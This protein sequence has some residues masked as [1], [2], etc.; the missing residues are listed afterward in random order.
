M[1]RSLILLSLGLLL[2]PG[3]SQAKDTRWYKGNTHCHTL[4]SDGDDY[5]RRVIRW[6]RDH[7]YNFISITD[8]NLITETRYLDTDPNDDFILI[9][10]EE[11]TDSFKGTPIH[12]NALGARIQIEPQR[13]DS[14]VLTLQNNVDAIRNAKAVPQINHPTWKWSFTDVEMAQLSGVRLFELYNVN[15]TSN[16]FSAGGRPGMEEI[17]DGILSKGVL[18]YG[19]ATD[20]AHD[21]MGE[22]RPDRANP[23]TGWIM[24]RAAKLTPKTILDAMERGDFYATVGVLL[25]D[26][27]ITKTEYALEIDPYSDLAYTTYFIGEGGKVLQETHG[28]EAAYTFT[29]DELYVRARV[30][31]S[32]GKFAC[33][34]PVF[35]SG[36]Q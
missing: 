32:S 18:M 31:A 3:L 25:K 15:D 19:V 13:G 12:L 33:T 8:H 30:F 5:P 23:G 4:H 10:G 26:I 11:V 24:V 28:L 2:I 21:Y 22:R 35:V 34:Q 17:W 36:K 27:R 1:R 9:Q 14:I 16:N 6:Y 7:E 20:D 29:G